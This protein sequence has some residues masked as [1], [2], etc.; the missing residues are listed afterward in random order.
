MMLG[1][2]VTL[3]FVRPGR[4]HAYTPVDVKL[5]PQAHTPR[6]PREATF[7]LL[8]EMR[9]K[10]RAVVAFQGVQTDEAA[11]RFSMG[12]TAWE[13]RIHSVVR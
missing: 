9:L 13:G 5:G 10:L 3:V 12:V 7:M 11:R 8:E 6:L 1:S 4:R 2:G